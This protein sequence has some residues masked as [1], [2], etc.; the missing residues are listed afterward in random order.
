MTFWPDPAIFETT[1]FRAETMIERFRMMAFLNAGL[2]IRFTDERPN[3]GRVS[4]E[5]GAEG[6]TPAADAPTTGTVVFK[7]AKASSTS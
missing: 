1:E 6:E 7:Y 2:E 4:T 3:H 5:A